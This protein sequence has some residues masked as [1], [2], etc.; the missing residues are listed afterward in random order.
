MRLLLI[1]DSYTTSSTTGQLYV[2]GK[3]ECFILEDTDRHLEQGGVK[4]P[5]VTC[6]PRGVYP[7]T[8]TYSARFKRPLPL[9]GNVAQ[10][11]GVRIHSGNTAADTEGCLLPGT[12]RVANTVGNSRV[13]FDQLFNKIKA[14][15]DS[16]QSVVLEIK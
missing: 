5:R 9:L 2:D 10:F 11:E 16:A 7:V 6:I 15:L 14:A 13:A 4:L 3:P 1:R 12:T 8:I